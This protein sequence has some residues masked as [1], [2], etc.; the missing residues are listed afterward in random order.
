VDEARLATER[1]ADDALVAG[2]GLVDAARGA[3]SGFLELE[4]PPAEET[5]GADQSDPAQSGG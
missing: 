2:Q 1:T 4:T 3:I 5:P